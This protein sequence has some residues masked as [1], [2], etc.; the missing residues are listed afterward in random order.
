MTEIKFCSH[1]GQKRVPD[2]RFCSACGNAFGGHAPSQNRQLL[3]YLVVIPVAIVIFAIINWGIL[4]PQKKGPKAASSQTPVEEHSHEEPEALKQLKAKA[5]SGEPEALM[6][7]AE[8][9]LHL[10][11]QDR[12]YLFQAAQTLETLL[13]DFPDHAYSLRMLGNLYYNLGLPDKAI[14]RYTRYLELHPGDANVH[15]DLGTQY[16]ARDQAEWAIRE[17]K[18]AI[19]LFPNF[20]N[21]HF[22]LYLAYQHLGDEANARLYK[23]KAERISQE[24]GQKLAPSPQLPRLPGDSEVAASGVPVGMAGDPGF[25]SLESYF[26]GHEIV[27]PKMTGFQ[28]KSGTAVL[29][30]RNFPMESMPPFVRQT[31]DTK[32]QQRLEQIGD[33][34]ALEIRDADNQR[35]MAQYRAP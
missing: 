1:C 30:V 20:Y 26:R 32:V 13:A 34:A 16:L 24:F 15:V 3:G 27:G 25:E 4:S 28:V 29:L 35:I 9:Q 8:H 18:E 19:R 2:A 22:N 31:F 33:G 11:E 23:N 12:D 5:A 7:L 6:T 10:S 14:E 21:A 17:Y